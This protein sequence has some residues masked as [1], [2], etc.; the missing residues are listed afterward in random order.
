MCRSAVQNAAERVDERFLT[1]ELFERETGVDADLVA[2]TLGGGDWD[3]AVRVA[4]G[5]ERHAD[6][7]ETGF[8]MSSSIARVVTTPSAWTSWCKRVGRR[9]TGAAARSNSTSRRREPPGTGGETSPRAKRR[10]TYDGRR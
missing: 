1:P 8:R 2:E 9:A 7:P 10:I 6:Q 5:T 4:I 3:D